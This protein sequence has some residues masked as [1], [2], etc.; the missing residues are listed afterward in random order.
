MTREYRQFTK[1]GPFPEGTILTHSL[2]R[3]KAKQL[4]I[5]FATFMSLGQP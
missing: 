5:D 3:L 4:G 2:R 1:D